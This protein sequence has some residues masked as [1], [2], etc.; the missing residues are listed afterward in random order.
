MGL[1]WFCKDSQTA[2]VCTCEQIFCRK[3]DIFG[4]VRNYTVLGLR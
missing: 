1:S 3:N 2:L 4:R